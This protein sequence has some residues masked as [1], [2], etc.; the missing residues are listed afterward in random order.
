VWGSTETNGVAI[1]NT[2]DDYQT[3]G[4]M[5]KGCPYYDIRLMSD[6][7]EVGPGE[8]GELFFK[9]PGISR[10][11]NGYPSLTD[12]EG[13]YASGDL[14]TKDENGFFHFVERKNGMVKSAGLKVYPLQVE[15][16]LI[17]HPGIKEIAVLGIPDSR[18][19]AVLKAF[20]VLQDNVQV[21]A[22]DLRSFCKGRIP[23]YMIPKEF[24]FL[25]D[26]PKIGSGK[27]NKKAIAATL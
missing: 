25:G 17:N 3:S 4:S 27:I 26:L 18:K 24:E 16:S 8:I 22:D 6:G 21:D 10:R 20:V 2:F 9:G 7:R 11:Y 23:N 14:A 5:G 12:S 13:W 1:A 15:L 19:G